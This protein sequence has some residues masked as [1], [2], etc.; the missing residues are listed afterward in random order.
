MSWKNNRAE[1]SMREADKKIMEEAA[2]RKASEMKQVGQWTITMTGNDKYTK[3][4]LDQ[5]MEKIVDFSRHCDA[6]TPNIEIS[7]DPII[8]D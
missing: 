5:I 8:E 6:Q 1:Q 7:I 4:E 3:E 2:K